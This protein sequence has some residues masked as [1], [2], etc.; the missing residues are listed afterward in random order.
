MSEVKFGLLHIFVSVKPELG[1]NWLVPV[2]H[3]QTL[4]D[5]ELW[6]SN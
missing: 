6:V 3:P 2:T 5:L 1:A 4:T